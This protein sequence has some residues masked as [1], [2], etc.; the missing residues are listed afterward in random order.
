M[1]TRLG[2]PNWRVMVTRARPAAIV[3]VIVC[4]ATSF[5]LAAQAQAKTEPPTETPTWAKTG[6]LL[7][8]MRG[9]YL[10]TANMIFN[11]QTHD[12]AKKTGAVRTGDI[13]WVQWGGSL[14]SGW[15]DVDYAAAVLAEA[16]PLLLVP[17]RVCQNG[18]PVPVGNADWVKYTQDMLHAAQLA[19][20]ASKTRSQEKVSDATNDLT[21]ACSACHR[22]YRDRRA[23]SGVP[24]GDPATNP[25]R[26]SALSTTE[27]QRQ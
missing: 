24:A 8:L 12:P 3:V 11:V 23:A 10:P 5:H 7:E 13:D 16:T 15:E 21:D 17:G 25:L 4:A 18:K 22:T 26:C 14:Y 27:G 1:S 9:L 19:Y 20:Q 6:T 2:L